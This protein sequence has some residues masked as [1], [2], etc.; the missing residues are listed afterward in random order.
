TGPQGPQ[1]DQGPAGPQGPAGADGATG[2]QGPQGDQGPIG[3]TGP[4]GADGAD[5]ADGATGPQGPQGDQ[6]PVG[7]TGATGPAGPQGP[8]GDP[9]PGWTLASNEFN[10]DGTMTVNGTSGSGGPITSSLGAWLLDGNTNTGTKGFGTNSNTHVDFIT[11]SI[12]RGRF[13]NTGEMLWGSTTIIAPGIAGDVLHSY[14][15]ANTNNWSFNGINTSASG[16]GIFGSNQSTSNGY[17]GIEGSTMGTGSGIK[18]MHMATSGNGIGVHGTTNS[19]A[20]GWA[21]YF[22]GDVGC[23]GLYYGSDER[24]KKNIQPMSSVIDKIMN[25]N[26]RT[27]Q[28]NTDEFKGMGFTSGDLKFGFMAQE[29]KLVFPEVVKQKS[30]PNPYN[31]SGTKDNDQMYDGFHMVDYISLI[32]VLTKGIQEQ[33]SMIEN[34]SDKVDHSIGMNPALIQNRIV[35]SETGRMDTDLFLASPST[36]GFMFGV[37]ESGVDGDLVVRTEGIVFIDI[38][39]SNGNILNGDFVTVGEDGKALKS[40]TSEWVIGKALED[41]IDGK[42]KVR[43]DFRFKQ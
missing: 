11:N 32:P 6:G 41:S 35:Y 29:L 31:L 36:K 1:G 14:V 13:M 7:A 9:G 26:V 40:T 10:L 39:S 20:A 17:A 42:V 37:C 21:G 8:Q 16:G 4:A 2:P 19:P 5:G 18:G 43:I 28:M 25:L 30:I 27:Y 12:T 24:W 15:T 22:E 33:Q 23:T 38:D 34:L 3:L